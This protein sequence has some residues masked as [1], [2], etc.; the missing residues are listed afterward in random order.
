MLLIAVQHQKVV[1][2]EAETDRKRAVIEAEKLSQVATITYKQ[3]IMEKESEKRISEIEGTFKATARVVSDY[4]LKRI[5][6]KYL[7]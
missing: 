3:K 5:V 4:I 2:K 7:M 6:Y 1:E